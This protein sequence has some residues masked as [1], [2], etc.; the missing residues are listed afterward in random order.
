MVDDTPA[1][2][3][4]EVAAATA[5]AVAGAVADVAEAAILAGGDS[6]THAELAAALDARDAALRSEI[7][8]VAV[9]AAVADEAVLETA[10]AVSEE[11]ATE[12][13]DEAVE[14]EVDQAVNSPEPRESEPQSDHEPP[15][16]RA[17][18]GNRF[19][20]GARK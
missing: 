4:A 2:P 7:A 3:A 6:V 11:T 17:G 10:V 12:E 1:E 9:A 5:E 14:V 15:R 13:I 19:L 8:G 18:Y 16:H 20:F